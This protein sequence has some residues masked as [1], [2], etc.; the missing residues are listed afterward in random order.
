MGECKVLTEAAPGDDHNEELIKV[1]V[2]DDLYSNDYYK[3]ANMDFLASM[4]VE[5]NNPTLEPHNFSYTT[6]MCIG[7][8]GP[9]PEEHGIPPGVTD[10]HRNPP[11][12]MRKVTMCAEKS[13]RERPVYPSGKK[14]CLA[15]YVTVG[16]CKAW[17]LC[18][19]G[20]TTLG[21]TPAF[22]HVADL[23]VFPLSNPHTLQLGTV[24]S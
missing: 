8:M 10:K 11:T 5:A 20:S 21:V 13:T 9:I 14:H 12:C 19:S 23:T 15:T 16:R 24:G 2:P 18:D 3:N 4:H 7:A 1:E 6:P 22:S 17:T